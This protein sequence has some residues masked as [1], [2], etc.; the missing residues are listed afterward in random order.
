MPSQGGRSMPSQTSPAPSQDGEILSFGQQMQDQIER[1]GTES[2]LRRS[3]F[4]GHSD[5]SAASGYDTASEF[6][7]QSVGGRSNVQ[8]QGSGGSPSYV[9]QRQP[10]GSS[11]GMRSAAP[12]QRTGTQSYGDS[13]FS[14]ASGYDTASDFGMSVSQAGGVDAHSQRSGGSP[15]YVSQRQPGGS[16]VGMRSAAPSQRTATQSYTTDSEFS[17]ASGY[18]TAS[19]FG[20]QSVGTSGGRQSNTNSSQRS[21][22][23][24]SY[25]TQSQ[26][27]NSGSASMQD[28]RR[29][30]FSTGEFFSEGGEA[31]DAP[32]AQRDPSLQ[33]AMRMPSTDQ[34][35]SFVDAD[36]VAFQILNDEQ[37]AKFDAGEG[38]GSLPRPP[39]DLVLPPGPP[40]GGDGK[41]KKKGLF[42]KIFGR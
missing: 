14:M 1:N 15:S 19:G 36:Q 42:G 21:G 26:F 34:Q 10:G 35:R 5:H 37:Q 29:S 22:A 41:P 8:S 3:Q 18:D 13:E 9:S 11:A 28:D 12:S 27:G 32:P 2:Y 7:M 16:S 24:S 23:P 30:A 40:S 17:M 25:A 38:L 20:M 33:M 4:P 6:G 31:F 39:A